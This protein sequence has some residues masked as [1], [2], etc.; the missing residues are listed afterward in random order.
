M[1]GP[2]QPLLVAAAAVV[3][4]GGNK[5]MAAPPFVSVSMASHTPSGC[6]DSSSSVTEFNFVFRIVRVTCGFDSVQRTVSRSE[7]ASSSGKHE[8]LQCAAL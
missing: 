6:C 2:T 5:L 7:Q 3:V 8:T 4:A 1:F